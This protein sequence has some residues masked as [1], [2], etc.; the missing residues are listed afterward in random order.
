[1]VFGQNTVKI[2]QERQLSLL[3]LFTVF[4]PQKT[5]QNVGLDFGFEHRKSGKTKKLL[6]ESD[7][8]SDRRG[9]RSVVSLEAWILQI[10]V[11][12]MIT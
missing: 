8:E 12:V 4:G 11:W 5:W 3:Y 10:M 7:E 9:D 6:A 1:L 2:I